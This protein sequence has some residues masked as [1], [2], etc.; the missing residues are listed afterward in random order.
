[1]RLNRRLLYPVLFLLCIFI[2]YIIYPSDEK[3]IIQVIDKSEE[4]IINEDI[5]KL[6]DTISYNYMDG[7]GNGYLQVKH[8][9]LNAFKRLDD[10]VVDRNILRISISDDTAEAE[11][12]VRAIATLG[13]ERGYIIGD[14]VE[15]ETIKVFFEK[16]PHKWL[17]TKVEG[18][19][20]N[21][22]QRFKDSVEK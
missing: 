16:S 9:M 22:Y 13:E 4:A 17:I 14:A 5:E 10:I 20:E 8:I 7:Y 1:M 15:P 11:L 6:M 3:R 12:S 19:F 18:V 21:R 2:I